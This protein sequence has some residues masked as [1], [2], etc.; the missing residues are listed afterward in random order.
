[1]S[2]NLLPL[3]GFWQNQH[4]NVN[5]LCVCLEITCVMEAFRNIITATIDYQKSFFFVT[6]KALICIYLT[7][8]CAVYCVLC[9]RARGQLR[10]KA[11]KSGKAW[12]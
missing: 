3:R 5:F 1:M 11:C 10:A 12:G 4:D 8:N 9:S 7:D 2:I 6:K